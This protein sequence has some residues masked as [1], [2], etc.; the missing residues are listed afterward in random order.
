[1]RN[2]YNNNNKKKLIKDSI[3]F[4]RFSNQLK[5]PV[6]RKAELN[7]YVPLL[8]KKKKREKDNDSKNIHNDF[9]APTVGRSNVKLTLGAFPLA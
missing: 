1:M 7:H 3:C 4:T 6:F 2:R 9:N 5:G 8:K